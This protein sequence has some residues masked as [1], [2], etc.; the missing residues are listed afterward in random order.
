MSTPRRLNFG[1]GPAHPPMAP[2]ERRRVSRLYDAAKSNFDK[3]LKTLR[4]L[5]GLRGNASQNARKLAALEREHV[6]IRGLMNAAALSLRSLPGRR[7][8]REEVASRRLTSLLRPF[9]AKIS[10]IAHESGLRAA[11]NAGLAHY[12]ENWGSEENPV[13]AGAR[14]SPNRRTSPNRQPSPRNTGL[15]PRSPATLAREQELGIAGGFRHRAASPNASKITWSRN[16][17][18]KI[19]I[20]KT[21]NNLNLGFTNAQRRAIGK[22][23]E[24]AAMRE[25]QRLARPPR[26]PS[27]SP[28]RSPPRSPHRSPSRSPPRRILRMQSPSRSP[29]RRMPSPTMIRRPT[30]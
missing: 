27:R 5:S 21:M 8:L 17:N 24:E 30:P 1:R 22:M 26:S 9:T 14:K 29:P 25:L 11:R 2:E 20:Y 3:H 23:S 13:W 10:N 28:S 18:G 7:A 19:S 6:R 4:K 15:R 16:A 12:Y